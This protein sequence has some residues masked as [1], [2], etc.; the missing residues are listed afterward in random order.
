MMIVN[1]FGG[2]E[3]K[4]NSGGFKGGKL[5]LLWRGTYDLRNSQLAPGT[6]FLI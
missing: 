1:V 6:I 5:L 2:H 3:R 4:I